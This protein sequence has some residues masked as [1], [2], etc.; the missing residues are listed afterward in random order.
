MALDTGRPGILINWI[1]AK[2]RNVSIMYC[3]RSVKF[4]ANILP[5]LVIAVKAPA[6][7]IG[8]VAETDSS[9]IVAL[10]ITMGVGY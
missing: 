10:I 1:S 8:K 4:D 7:K 6:S 5:G 2:L 3:L 9:L